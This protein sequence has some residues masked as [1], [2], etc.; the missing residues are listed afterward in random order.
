MLLIHGQPFLQ[1]RYKQQLPS[2]DHMLARLKQ[3]ETKRVRCVKKFGA[4]VKERQQSTVVQSVPSCAASVECGGTE[5]V[6][7]CGVSDLCHNLCGPSA[8]ELFSSSSKAKKCGVS[9]DR[10]Y[11]S[12]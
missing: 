8:R 6:C 12:Y 4:E 7:D 10:S 2:I 11:S 9:L 5:L 3:E 1:Q